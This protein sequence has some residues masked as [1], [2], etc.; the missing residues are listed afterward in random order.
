MAVLAQDVVLRFHH[1]RQGAHQD[2]ALAGQVAVDFILEGGGEEVARA[3]RDAQRP[4]CARSARPVKSWWTAKAA[5]DPAAGEEVGAHAGAGA[6]GGNQ[7]HIHDT[8]AG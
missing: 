8:R 1:A 7:D 4:G 2:A 6:L 3:N 5:V